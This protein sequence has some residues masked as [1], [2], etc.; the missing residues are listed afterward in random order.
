LHPGWLTKCIQAAFLH[1]EKAS[2][3]LLPARL[4]PACSYGTLQDS[5]QNCLALVPKP[6]RR[7]M[8]KLMNKDKIILRFTVRRPL[9]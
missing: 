6:P 1:A 7:D 3:P 5:L 2:D 9:G 4:L 8:H